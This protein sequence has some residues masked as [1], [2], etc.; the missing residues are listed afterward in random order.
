MELK[1]NGKVKTFASNKL[2]RNKKTKK[3]DN[4]EW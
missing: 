2:K 3:Q 1:L 4:K